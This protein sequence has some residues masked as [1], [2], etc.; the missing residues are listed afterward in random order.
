M[1]EVFE[2]VELSIVDVGVAVVAPDGEVGK[3]ERE[4][5]ITGNAVE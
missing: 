2:V 4:R 3:A 1:G 5:V